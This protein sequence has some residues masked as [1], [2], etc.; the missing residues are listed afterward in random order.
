MDLGRRTRSWCYQID[1]IKFCG[2]LPT[3]SAWE[4][5]ACSPADTSLGWQA[6]N[7]IRTRKCSYERCSWPSVRR[8]C[9]W[10]YSDL[11]REPTWERPWRSRERSGPFS[12]MGGTPVSRALSRIPSLTEGFGL[13]PLEAMPSSKRAVSAAATMCAF[14]TSGLNFRQIAANSGVMVKGFNTPSRRDNSTRPRS[15]RQ[16]RKSPGPATSATSCPWAD[17]SQVRSTAS[18]TWPLAFRERL[19][20]ALSSSRDQS[21]HDNN[22]PLATGVRRQL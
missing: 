19:E 16:V 2:L 6:R 7:R 8:T 15:E 5:T 22:T 17:C 18:S 13:P 20:N 9:S 21:P 12:G 14:K 4:S 3:S 10:P 11:P 1:P